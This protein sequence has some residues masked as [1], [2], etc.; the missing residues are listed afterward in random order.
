MKCEV[1]AVKAT[2]AAAASTLHTAATTH[3]SNH[4]LGFPLLANRR[5]DV[6]L[7]LAV[8]HLLQISVEFY[9]CTYFEI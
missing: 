4:Q 3:P 1:P 7:F 6:L 8:Q 5:K 2:H 9:N